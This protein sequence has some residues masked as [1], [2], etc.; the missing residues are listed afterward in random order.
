[1]SIGSVDVVNADK[2]HVF[3]FFLTINR[4]SQNVIY[5][6]TLT[7]VCVAFL[8]FCREGTTLGNLN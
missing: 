8:R 5:I 4:F 2:G 1:M 6:F 3:V 7:L